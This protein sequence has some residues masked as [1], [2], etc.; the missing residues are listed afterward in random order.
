[1]V[2]DAALLNTQHYKV[3]ING[4]VEKSRERSNAL[5]TSQC[6]SYWKGCLWVTFDQGRQLSFTYIEIL[7]SRSSH[8]LC[9]QRDDLPGKIWIV[10]DTL[11]WNE[12]WDFLSIENKAT[13]NFSAQSWLFIRCS[14]IEDPYVFLRLLVRLTLRFRIFVKVCCLILASSLW[15]FFPMSRKP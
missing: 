5:P 8:S 11:K 9:L 12:E 15:L 4:K 3:W 14:T 2:L 7:F 6:C 1:M 13:L 10:S